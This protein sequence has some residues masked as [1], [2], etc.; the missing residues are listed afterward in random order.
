MEQRPSLEANILSVS[1]ETLRIIWNPAVPHVISRAPPPVPIL[2][3]T[4]LFHVPSYLVNM[5]FN[6]IL[7]STPRSSKW[8][9]SLRFPH[10]TV[11][12]SPLPNTC[13]MH[14]PSLWKEHPNTV[15]WAVQ[16]IKL[17][18]MQTAYGLEGLGSNIVSGK[19]F[20]SLFWNF[21]TGCGAHPPS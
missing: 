19:R 13:H 6:I 14:R 16:I 3:H 5:Y 8:S 12:T 17:L 11:R 9:L 7:P 20:F 4:N 10:Q 15:L 2:N 21:Q 1:Q 18:F